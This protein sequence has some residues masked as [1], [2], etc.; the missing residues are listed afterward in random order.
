MRTSAHA[1]FLKDAHAH[2]K[3]FKVRTRTRKSRVFW[4]YAPLEVQFY[5]DTVDP[6]TVDI[7][8]S[9]VFI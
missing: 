5:A 1:K 4:N 8:A 9:P 3:I 7:F 2:A 6:H